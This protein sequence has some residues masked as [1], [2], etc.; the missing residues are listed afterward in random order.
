MIAHLCLDRKGTAACAV[1]AAN[2]IAVA[3]FLAGRIRFTDIYKTI[4]NTLENTTFIAEPGYD[5]YVAVNAEACAKA[6]EYIDKL[7]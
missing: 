2:E 7:K 1:N 4:M 6:S 5:D 3:A